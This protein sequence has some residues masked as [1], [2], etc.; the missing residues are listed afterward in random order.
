[1]QK[2]FCSELCVCAWCGFKL[3]KVAEDILSA[4]VVVAVKT[5]LESVGLL[6]GHASYGSA[7]FVAV[8]RDWL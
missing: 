1:M 6:D 2:A 4:D 5:A 7:G 3:K 8:S